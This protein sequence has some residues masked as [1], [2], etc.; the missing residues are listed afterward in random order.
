MNSTINNNSN[1]SPDLPLNLQSIF[2]GIMLSDGSLYKS[3]P[4]ANTRFE[5]SFGEKYKDFA[6]HIGDLFKDYMNNPI[7][8]LTIK[9]IKKDYINYRLKT[10]SLPLFNLYYDM[11]YKLDIEKNKHI[12]IVPT[13][14]TKFMNPEV[15]AYLIQGDGNFDKGRKRVRIYTNSYKKSEVENLALAIKTKLNIKVSVLYDRKDQWILTIG[16][17]NLELL[18]NIIYPHLHSSMLYRVGL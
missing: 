14:I 3:S 10:K 13:N 9:G 5:M 7:K 17:N 8:P 2:I 12:K 4:N 1:M 16:A 18:R 15:L 11:F 6:Y